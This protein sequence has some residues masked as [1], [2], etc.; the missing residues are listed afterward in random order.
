MAFGRRSVLPVDDLK[1][2]ACQQQGCI[3]HCQSAI[4]LGGSQWCCVPQG[5]RRMCLFATSCEHCGYHSVTLIYV[6]TVVVSLFLS[7]IASCLLVRSHMYVCMFAFVCSCLVC[8]HVRVMSTSARKDHPIF[9]FI[10]DP[11]HAQVCLWEHGVPSV[12]S[13]RRL[14][15]SESTL[16]CGSSF[17]GPYCAISETGQWLHS[18]TPYFH[19]APSVVCVFVRVLVRV[20][21]CVRL[22][23][24]MCVSV[25]V[26]VCVCLFCCCYVQNE[27]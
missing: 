11:S 23:V 3:L 6:F 20:F 16:V 24:C 15:W 2:L 25:C 18:V 22:F 27:I 19:S 12:V 9:I 8:V 21:V 26:C 13:V 1:K 17:S 5:A 7:I 14:E 4:S 10:C